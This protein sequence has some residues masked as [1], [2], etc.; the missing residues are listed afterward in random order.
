MKFDVKEPTPTIFQIFSKYYLWIAYL[1]LQNETQSIF[2][3]FDL[4]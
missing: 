3:L 2:F 1:E 4:G